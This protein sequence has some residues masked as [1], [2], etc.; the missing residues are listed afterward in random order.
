MKGARALG[1]MD[2]SNGLPGKDA[3]TWLLAEGFEKIG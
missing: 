1:A 3:Q 2:R